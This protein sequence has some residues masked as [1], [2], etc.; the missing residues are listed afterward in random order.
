MAVVTIL[1]EIKTLQARAR[2]LIA[3]AKAEERDLTADESRDYEGIA[4]RLASLAQKSQ[5]ER[6]FADMLSAVNGKSVEALPASV[7][8]PAGDSFGT[9]V[10]RHEALREFVGRRGGPL[11]T[12]ARFDVVVT[13][14][15][16]VPPAGGWPPATGA[17]PAPGPLP[18]MARD[19]FSVLPA[20]GGTAV[21]ARDPG[22][23][24][25]ADIVAPGGLKPE[26]TLVLDSV[27]D[28]LVKIAHFAGVA[29]ETVEDVV[30][31]A[32]WLNAVMILGVLDREDAYLVATLT[33]LT[34]KTPD[35]PMAAGENAADAIL[36]AA[37]GIQIAS[38]M[39]VDGVIVGPDV[40]AHLLTM[41]AEGG[42][43]YLV[44]SPLAPPTNM[45]WGRLNLAVSSNVAPGTAIIGG[46]RRAAAIYRKNAIRVDVTESH[47]DF[48]QRNLTAVRAEV[49]EVLGVYTPKAIGTASALVP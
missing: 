43:T 29:N 26:T 39:P 2:T 47:A 27:S 8:T 10:A 3:K 5:R 13:N 36:A 6:S 7:T 35:R 20:E 40:Y 34:G 44:G 16:L 31:F 11:P 49:K 33:A 12:T 38:K 21:Y 15:A 42:G 22:Q 25:A 18:L 45:I 32:S 14:A 37:M 9:L 48:F 4:A 24:T 1:D 30:G 46:F 28:P 19:M 41:K 23:T 17:P